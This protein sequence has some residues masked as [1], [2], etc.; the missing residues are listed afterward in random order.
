MKSI[1]TAAKDYQKNRQDSDFLI[2]YQFVEK[3]AQI[4][5]LKMN[6]QYKEDITQGAAI[7][8]IKYIDKFKPTKQFHN[9]CYT[10][11][12]NETL[13]R[14]NDE[15]RY[16]YDIKFEDDGFEEDIKPY[17]HLSYEPEYYTE[18]DNIL[19]DQ[20]CLEA[21][22]EF[23]PNLGLR[24]RDLN[25]NIITIEKIKEM[26]TK[27]VMY[28]WTSTDLAEE[29]EIKNGV[30]NYLL[31]KYRFALVEYIRKKFKH[32]VIPE[33]LYERRRYRQRKSI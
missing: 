31:R 9:W 8:V 6:I 12:L 10:L 28:G 21:L 19:D 33:F 18:E 26:F 7:R 27:H 14:I 13:F 22:T 29:Y 3:L 32:K 23:I 24:R 17:M 2:I 15:K 4:I 11:V 1:Q 5:A 30:V 20:D 16:R 25:D